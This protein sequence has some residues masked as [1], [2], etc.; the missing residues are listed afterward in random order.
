MVINWSTALQV[1]HSRSTWGEWIPPYIEDG[2][3]GS[4]GDVETSWDLRQHQSSAII[5]GSFQPLI[6]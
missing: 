3:D 4:Q 1:V 5:Q 6:P 2:S